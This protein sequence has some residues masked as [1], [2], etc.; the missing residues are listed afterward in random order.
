MEVQ[1]EIGAPE[2][3]SELIG[4]D[5]IIKKGFFSFNHINTME[6]P[7]FALY[8]GIPIFYPDSY[9]GIIPLAVCTIF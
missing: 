7:L 1:K 4:C 2:M 5:T 8:L 6:R 3:P 9:P